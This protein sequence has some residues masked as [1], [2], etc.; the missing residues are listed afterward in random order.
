MKILI[1]EEQYEMLFNPEFWVRRNY[2]HIENE[3]KDT[4]SFTSDKICRYDTY[5]EFESYLFSVFMDGLHGY[6]YDVANLD[7]LGLKSTLTDMFYVEC[8]EFYFKGKEL[9]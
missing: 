4:M 3:L 9:C 1:T 8:T 6:Y 5:E 2:S 7:Y